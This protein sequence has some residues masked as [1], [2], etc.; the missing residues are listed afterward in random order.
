MTDTR[1]NEPIKTS[2]RLLILMRHAKSDWGDESLSDH[3]RPLNERGI[4]DTPAMAQWF[5]E[6]NAVPDLILCSAATR[7]RQTA[8]LLRSEWD[9]PPEVSYS[10]S[11]YLATPD[12]I[13]QT[14][15]SDGC[16][17]SILMVVA[18]NPGTAHLISSFAEQM[19]DVPT[20]AAGVFEVDL[21][22]WADLRSS[23]SPKMLRYMRPK[24]LR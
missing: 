3:D 20:A 22:D 24:A 9:P 17:A 2:K 18:H 12:K 8:T 19:I 16:D 23:D 6:I 10:E 13:L 4:G 15:R 21:D 14:I 1:S 7:T 5:A 11:L